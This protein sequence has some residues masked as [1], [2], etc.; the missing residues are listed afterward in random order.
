[1]NMAMI[2]RYRGSM[3]KACDT[4]KR[5]ILTRAFYGCKFDGFYGNT[6][7]KG[8]PKYYFLSKGSPTVVI[9]ALSVAISP[10]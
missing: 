2:Y 5:Q 10:V 7:I 1:M 6:N 8:S 3:Q 4:M 9:Y